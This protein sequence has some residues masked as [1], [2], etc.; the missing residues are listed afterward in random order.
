MTH[1]AIALGVALGALFVVSVYLEREAVSEPSRAALAIAQG[2]LA[3]HVQG[4]LYP[5]GRF[6]SP[7]LTSTCARF[8]LVPPRDKG[9]EGWPWCAAAIH[10]CFEQAVPVP[11]DGEP[12]VN[13]CPR[14]A[15]ALHLWDTSPLASRTQL[16][17]PGDVFVLGLGGRE[18]GHCGFVASLRAQTAGSFRRASRTHRAAGAPRG[19]PG[20]KAPVLGT[21]RRRAGRAQG[22]WPQPGIEAQVFRCSMRRIDVVVTPYSA[23]MY[24]P[25]V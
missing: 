15:G 11:P 2:E 3:K 17:A 4:G 24:S 19:T 13:P 21:C 12:Y 25:G 9:D 1:A 10:W 20:E 8:G 23:A 22:L 7:R 6:R 18:G 14:T 5:Y 16:P